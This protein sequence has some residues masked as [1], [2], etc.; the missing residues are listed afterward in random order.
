M[1]NKLP[2]CPTANRV[3]PA[4]ETCMEA[5]SH[6]GEDQLSTESIF[7]K[8]CTPFLA[9]QDKAERLVKLSRDTTVESKRIIFQLQRAVTVDAE[10]NKGIIY[11][12]EKRLLALRK[13]HLKG[14]A[15]ELTSSDDVLRFLRNYKAGL[16]EFVEAAVFCEFLKSREFLT[17]EKLNASLVFEA[18]VGNGFSTYRMFIPAEDYTMGLADVAGKILSVFSPS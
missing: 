10:K 16:Q 14:I 5:E 12:A 6:V 13:T 17:W 11:D 1:L 18:D 8:L 3:V 15:K 4:N 2:C 9:S 7:G